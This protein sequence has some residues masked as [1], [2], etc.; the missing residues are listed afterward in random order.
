MGSERFLRDKEKELSVAMRKAMKGVDLC[1]IEGC[2][3]PELRPG[4]GFCQ[5]HWEIDLERRRE[6]E[7][8]KRKIKA[9]E[10]PREI[11]INQRKEAYFQMNR[12]C[13]NCGRAGLLY[14]QG[15]ACFRPGFPKKSLPVGTGLWTLCTDCLKEL[16]EKV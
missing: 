15:R 14:G 13:E 4:L 11:E 5:H 10:D 16:T 7:E 3:A 1:S 6:V 2:L 9:E 8:E 12:K